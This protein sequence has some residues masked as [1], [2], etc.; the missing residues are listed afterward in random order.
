M[1]PSLTHSLSVCLSVCER[2][3]GRKGGGMDVD[4]KR[5]CVSVHIDICVCVSL[6]VFAVSLCG[7][8][9]QRER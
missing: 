3:R 8:R 4:V 9:L 5:G 1:S 7:G 6:C 2:G